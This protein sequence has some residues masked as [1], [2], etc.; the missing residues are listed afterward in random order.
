MKNLEQI[1]K[2]SIVAAKLKSL[3]NRYIAAIG[4]PLCDKHN[5]GFNVDTRFSMTGTMTVSLDAYT[6]NYGS[7]SCYVFDNIPQDIAQALFTKAINKH[8]QLLLDTMA[9]IAELEASKLV[10]SAKAE[11]AELEKS[12]EA[13]TK[14]ES[15]PAT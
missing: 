3:W 8:A 7:S 6:G 15:E 10:S 2:L 5:F 12:I 14:P 13:A 11:L 9:E 4:N 1:K